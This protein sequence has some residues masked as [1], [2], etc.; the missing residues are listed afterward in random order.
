MKQLEECKNFFKELYMDVL[1]SGG[2]DVIDEYTNR[3]ITRY[4]VF[5]DTMS[6]VYGSDFD[7]IKLLWIKEATKEYYN[8]VSRKELLNDKD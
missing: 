6:F 1:D 4:S 2:F 7:R 5:I 3:D 8:F